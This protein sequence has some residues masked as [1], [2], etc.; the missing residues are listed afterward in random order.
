MEQK[1]LKLFMLL[2]GAS[3]PGRHVEQHDVFC[4]IAGSL[5]ELI[6]DIKNF[7]PEAKGL[8]VDAWREIT[9]VD[10]YEV[11][12]ADKVE[13]AGKEYHLF[14][15]NLGGYVA[16]LFDEPHYKILTVQPDKA[17]AMKHAKST[18]FYKEMR[19]PKASSHVD[20]KYGLDVDDIY[21]VN[22]ILPP[23]QKE[24]YVIKIIKNGA[25]ADDKINLGYFKLNTLR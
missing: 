17:T 18:Q 13:P 12:I 5:K 25:L 1:R 7:W 15:L 8:H 14:F 22:E 10:G 6:P 4:G 21:D 16:G 3:I 20:D 11:M 23:K 9:C 2:L 24:Q 19:F